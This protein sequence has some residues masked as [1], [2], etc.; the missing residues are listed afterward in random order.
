MRAWWLSLGLAACGAAPVVVSGSPRLPLPSRSTAS[1]S[2][3]ELL[4]Q[5]CGPSLDERERRLWAEFQG[6]NVPPF[7]GCLVPVTTQALV[8]GQAH[9][10][11]FWCT[12]DYF[13]F[14]SDADWLRMPM[15]P[16]LATHIADALD[17]MLPTRRMVDAIWLQAALKLSPVTFHPKQH[18]IV[19]VELFAEH[20]QRIEQQ[21]AGA[22]QSLLVAG[23]KK[24][25]VISAL[26]AE[27]PRRV[28]I[29]GWHQPSGA[30]IQPLSKAHTFPHV[31]YSHGARLVAS[32]MQVDGRATTVAAVLA[33]PQLH[34]LLSDEGPLRASRYAVPVAPR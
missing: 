26:L 8:D 2:G 16:A 31:D 21:R 30:P 27:W 4:P 6:G 1:P 33:D 20:H 9:S 7:L 34:V 5:L 18:D 22:A 15:S 3:S 12:P 19:A 11:T 17:C 28:C 23:I 13:G 32:S 29:Y 14:G 24:D 25:V 10:A